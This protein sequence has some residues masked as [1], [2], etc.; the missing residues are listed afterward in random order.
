MKWTDDAPAASSR[1]IHGRDHEFT[2]EL[3][4][5][6]EG[7]FLALRFTGYGNMGAYLA[8]SRR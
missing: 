2:G 4:L 1:I 8:R 3:A 7:N 5:D 6:A